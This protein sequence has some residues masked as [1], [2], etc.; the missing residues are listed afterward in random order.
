MPSAPS[1]TPLYRTHVGHCEGREVTTNVIS[2]LCRKLVPELL[3]KSVLRNMDLVYSSS[4]NLCDSERLL[5]MLGW[6]AVAG[7]IHRMSGPGGPPLARKL[8]TPT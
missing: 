6:E 2:G 4:R 5:G 3:L 8:L 1:L 7:V